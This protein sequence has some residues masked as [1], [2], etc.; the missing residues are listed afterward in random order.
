MNKKITALILSICMGI[1]PLYGCASAEKE[2]D[3]KALSSSQV[4]TA[5][6]D[7][8]LLGDV[9]NEIYADI[10]NVSLSDATDKALNDLF[11]INP[12]DVVSY[13][14]RYT[15]FKYG[16]A[17]VM[18]VKPKEDKKQAV[19]DSFDTRKRT[20]IAECENYDV[21]N[22]YQIAQHAEIYER[23]GYIIMLMLEDNDAAKKIIEKHIV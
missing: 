4:T 18:I 20:R 21:H 19:L 17:D 8:E 2:A 10:D 9:I 3:D 5:E 14:I 16:V 7:E 22:A 13:A 1:M 12:D 23:G 11:F 15:D 6:S